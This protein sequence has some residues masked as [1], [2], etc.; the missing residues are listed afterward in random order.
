MSKRELS[1]G[2][3]CKDHFGGRLYESRSLQRT[4]ERFIFIGRVDHLRQWLCARNFCDL[5]SKVR[6]VGSSGLSVP[7]A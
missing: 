1:A 4:F 5:L 2:N 3:F 7:F 6:I